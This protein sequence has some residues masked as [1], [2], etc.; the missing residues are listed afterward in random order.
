MVRE[1]VLV[2]ALAAIVFSPALILAQSPAQ[3]GGPD[4]I[5]MLKN[6][7]GCLGVEAARTMSGKQVLFAWFEN[8]QAVVI[9]V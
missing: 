6:T 5:A 3:Q 2:A 8:K 9:W 7:P 1:I 4:L